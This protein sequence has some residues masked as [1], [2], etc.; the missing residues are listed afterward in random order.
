MKKKIAK[1]LG[2]LNLPDDEIEKVIEIPKSS[3]LGDYALPCFFLSK[4]LKKNP[5][6][7]ANDLADKLKAGDDFEK[8]VAVGPYVN[9]FANKRKLVIKTLLSVLKEGDRY[10]KRKKEKGKK[11]VI[12]MSSPNIAKPF[13]IGHLRS[14]I[15]GNSISK[16]CEFRGYKTIKIN[17]LGDWGTQFGKLLF[18]YDKWGNEKKLKENPTN[19][20]LEIYIKANDEKY[21]EEARA[22]FKRLEGGD[23]KARSLWKK[24]RDFS[25][26]DFMKI[27]NTLGISFDSVSGE[28]FYDKK[29]RDVVS[30]LEK[31]KILLESEGAKIVNL[32]KEGLGVCLIMKSDGTTLYATRDITAAIDRYKKYRF[33]R[34]I[35]EVGSEQSLHFK[36]VFSILKIMGYSWAKDCLH[37]DHGLYLDEDGKKFSTR[38]GKTVF[39]KD[40]LEETINMAK[41]EI[42]K[43]DKVNK[44]ELDKRALAIARAAIFYG[45]LKNYR[46]SDMIFD[47]DRFV[48]FEGDTGPYL[49]YSYARAKS[50]LRKAKYKHTR[51]INIG[52]VS[53]HEKALASE[54]GAF[55][56][57]VEQAY[58]HFAP[59]RIAHYA[60]RLAQMF[61]EFYHKEKVIG[62]DE[63]EFRLALVDAF[64]VVLKSA[65]GLLGIKVIEEM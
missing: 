31:K 51:K 13:G 44:K 28:S 20:L 65:L 26:K 24:F 45:D 19:H 42:E 2:F 18:G 27:Y 57:V 6:H 62:S 11:I 48:S 8:I 53:E 22:W 37:V 52:D 41:K 55:P 32:E 7:I 35:Y 21:E 50:V 4:I 12:E 17:Y 39:M 40:I 33:D 29:M 23:K 54:I 56:Y 47:I 46:R 16:I 9:F 61:N 36:Q 38:K 1:L 15:I 59:D 58:S 5:S 25:V 49:L 34:M 10:G 60:Y 43:R 30:D 63:Q 14:T 3:E 64:S